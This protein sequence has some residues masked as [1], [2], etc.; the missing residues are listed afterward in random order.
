MVRHHSVRQILP[1][2]LAAAWS[3]GAF[4]AALEARLDRPAS[5]LGE[6]VSLTVEARGLEL[7][8]LDLTPLETE[9]EIFARTLSR[10]SAS[11]TLVLT[12]YPRVSGV[13]RIPPLPLGAQR[14]GALSLAVTTVRE[15][16]SPVAI[17]LQLTPAAPWVGEPARLSLSMC[18][19]DGLRW[20]RPV[21]PTGSG[22]VLRALNED[23]GPG[24]VAGVRCT[25]QRFHWVLVPTQSGVSR[26]V[27]PMLDAGLFGQRLRYPGPALEYVAGALPA[28]LPEAIPPLAPSVQAAPL[29][30]RWPLRRPL[31]WQ[32]EIEGAY[33]ADGLKSLLAMQ[34]RETPELGVYPPLIEPLAPADPASPQMRHRVTLTLQPR[35]SGELVLP[36]L[37][38]PWYDPVRERLDSRR[39]PAHSI[40]VVDPRIETARRVGA[41][42][43]GVAL[44]WVLGRRL[45][46]AVRWRLWRRRGLQAIVQAQD[47]AQLMQAVRQFSLHGGTPAPSLGVWLERLQQ[48]T[49]GQAAA[50]VDAVHRL[51]QQQFGRAPADLPALRQAFVDALVRVRPRHPR[52]RDVAAA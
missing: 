1:L 31:S 28:W 50:A 11:Q 25:Q 4:A 41:G 9:F 52:A 8:G 45:Q 49:G 38:L 16:Q 19:N 30:A 13:L 29:P 20:Q 2:L 47:P 22:R 15:D 24:E 37:N 21:L 10:A 43:V 39:V 34:L 26:V 51:E 40:M 36:A 3:S 42:L 48:E 7:D 32:I 23:E 27:M 17:D 35:A 14:T 18:D 5:L 12:L 44:L 6:A 46:R 33:S